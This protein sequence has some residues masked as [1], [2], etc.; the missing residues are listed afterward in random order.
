MVGFG[1]KIEDSKRPEWAEGYVVRAFTSN[2][3]TPA[4]IFSP[5]DGASRLLTFQLHTALGI[6]RTTSD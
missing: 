3:P 4:I 1:L 2:P 5:M 6:H